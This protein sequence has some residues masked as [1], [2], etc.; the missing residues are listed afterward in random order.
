MI[1]TPMVIA[2]APTCNTPNAAVTLIHAATPSYPDSARDL[3]LGPVTVVIQVAVNADGSLASAHILT[4]SHNF[5]VD[6]AALNAIRTSMY[7]PMIS[8]CNA[9]AASTNL[10]VEM[11]PNGRSTVDPGAPNTT[12]LATAAP[13]CNDPNREATVTNAVSPYI[14]DGANLARSVTV[15]VRVS[16]DEIGSVRALHVVQSSGDDSVDAA[17]LKAARESSYAPRYVGCMPV[18]GEYLFHVEINRIHAN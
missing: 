18:S 17:V 15:V 8:N 10:S 6:Q 12:T 9:V 2:D 13:Q 7:S 5:A 4:S 11:I 1:L 3:G 16:V 14:P